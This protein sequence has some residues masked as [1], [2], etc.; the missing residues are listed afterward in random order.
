MEVD[1]ISDD[2]M[3]FAI[4]ANFEAYIQFMTQ[5]DEA[6]EEEGKAEDRKPDLET[7]DE[8]LQKNGRKGYELVAGLLEQV[9]DIDQYQK[10]LSDYL[11][12]LHKEGKVKNGEFEDGISKLS[13]SIPDLSLDIPDIASN[14]WDQVL[15]PL[16][17]KEIVQLSKITWEA[18]P[19]ARPK[20]E[21]E[22]DDFEVETDPFFKLLALVLASVKVPEMDRYGKDWAS[23]IKVKSAKI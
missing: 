18:P 16:V 20:E 10:H 22:D 7:V 6:P 14:L 17:E 8:L 4:K 9:F 3:K 11:L 12:L 21:D 5:P 19:D 2:S 13:E 1:E 15:N 23:V